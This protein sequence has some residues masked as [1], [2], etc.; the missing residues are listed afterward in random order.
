MRLPRQ[1]APVRRT[2]YLEPAIDTKEMTVVGADPGD[3]SPLRLESRDEEPESPYK[4][5]SHLSVE[6]ACARR[7]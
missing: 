7:T 1:A 3:P 5:V 4:V 6:A 2:E